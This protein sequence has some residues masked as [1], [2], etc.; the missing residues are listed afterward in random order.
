LYQ[1]RW[2]YQGED[3]FATAKLWGESP[4][5]Q[6]LSNESISRKRERRKGKGK[7]NKESKGSPISHSH[8]FIHHCDIIEYR[9]N[10]PMFLALIKREYVDWTGCRVGKSLDGYYEYEYEYEYE[11]IALFHSSVVGGLSSVAYLNLQMKCNAM[12]IALSSM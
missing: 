6:H 2:F 11:S 8:C 5:K 4:K 1:R 3:Y 10:N 12:H 7:G 9:R